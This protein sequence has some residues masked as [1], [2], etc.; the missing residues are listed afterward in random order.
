MI[1]ALAGCKNLK[2]VSS[3]SDLSFENNTSTNEVYVLE[4]NKYIPYIVVS[5]KYNRNTLLLRKDVLDTPFSLNDYSSFYPDSELDII[6]NNDF[7][8]TLS[9]INDKILETEIS[10]TT[11]SAIGISGTSTENIKR[12]IFILS[13]S[14]MGISSEN[15]AQEGTLLKYFKNIDN[16]IALCNGKK[17]STW[18]RTP[19]TFY[20]SCS[21]V[22]G[23]N[24]K[25]GS[26]NV[27]D[28]NGIRPAFCVQNSLPVELNNDII[29]GK[30]IYVFSNITNNSN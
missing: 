14:E 5:S 26:T 1:L 7:Y 9:K 17:S 18:L 30:S 21:Y 15:M 19:N 2:K 12:K 27:Y 8:S 23:A 10:V 6:L 29:N 16:R 11:E 13:C 4:N 24:N 20:V 3:I 28:K 22:I 25:I